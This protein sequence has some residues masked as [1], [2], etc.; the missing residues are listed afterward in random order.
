MDLDYSDRILESFAKDIS[1]KNSVD[2]NID[3]L[4]KFIHH[5]F[6]LD[7]SANDELNIIYFGEFVD[8]ICGEESKKEKIQRL[9]SRLKQLIITAGPAKISER[10]KEFSNSQDKYPISLESRTSQ[11][12]TKNSTRFLD[13]LI[14][15]DPNYESMS[16]EIISREN[17][18]TSASCY[19]EV[20]DILS[21]II[22]SLKTI[23]NLNPYTHTK[24]IELEIV[25]IE[26]S[27][28]TAY[29]IIM[30]LGNNVCEKEW[31][32]NHK[33]ISS[34]EIYFMKIKNEFLKLVEYYD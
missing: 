5:L 30:D 23:H 6:H 34:I 12:P 13:I 18:F 15:K 33:T 24:I 25:M 17:D 29:G 20:G 3:E 16:S 32:E 7:V 21:G 19:P 2:Q 9:S 8:I 31:T 14:S 10:L 22:Q 28:N 11:E 27:I 26:S 1:E 4:I